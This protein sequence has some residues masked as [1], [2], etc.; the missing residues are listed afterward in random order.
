MQNEQMLMQIEDE[1]IT[2]THRVLLYYFYTKLNNAESFW[3]KH[4]TFSESIGVKGRIIVSDE[5]INGTI[6]GT[7]AQ[8][9]MY[10]YGLRMHP[11]F[12]KL[13]F[14]IDYSDHNTFPRLSVKYRKEIVAL[15][16]EEKNSKDLNPIDCTGTH[17][18]PKEFLELSR[19]KNAIIVDV[20]NE[21]EY[22]TGHF[23]NTFRPKKLFHYRDFPEWQKENIPEEYKENMHI[24]TVCTG[25]IKCEKL[26]GYLKDEGFKNVYQLNGGIATYLKDKEV[27]GADYDGQLYVFDDRIAVSYS[28]TR[29]KYK[30]LTKCV[31][32]Q[33][34]SERLVNSANRACNEQFFCCI[35]CQPKTLRSC[36][37]DCMVAEENEYLM[38]GIAETTTEAQKPT[39][40]N[41]KKKVQA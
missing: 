32:C 41:T 30:V 16:L 26:S 28:E 23:T 33:K 35:G 10:M 5:G 4:K 40:T 39:T 24:L 6:A 20:R 7:I 34:S 13:W 11:L 2:G 27:D 36:S 37:K 21:Y 22:E 38:C 1:K 8:T 12:R 3:K 19:Q 25:G 14:K 18:K 31:H 29:S 15:H 9:D 17:L